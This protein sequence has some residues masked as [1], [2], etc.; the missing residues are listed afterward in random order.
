MVRRGVALS[1]IE[2]GQPGGGVLIEP[3]RLPRACRAA[4][5]PVDGMRACSECPL[6]LGDRPH[7]PGELAGGRD[8]DDR[9]ALSAGFEASRPQVRCSRCC[10]VH[11][12]AIAAGG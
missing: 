2:R 7:E 3:S 8:R 6:D 10:A 5:D 12:I 1:R 11:A 9:A 4:T